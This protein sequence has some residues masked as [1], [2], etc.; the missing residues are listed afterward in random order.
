LRLEERVWRAGASLIG[1]G[2]GGQLSQK[3][4]QEKKHHKK[5]V[6]WSIR[7]FGGCLLVVS[8]SSA[9]PHPTRTQNNETKQKH[10]QAPTR[11]LQLARR[12]FS[13]HGGANL[14]LFIQSRI[15]ERFLSPLLSLSLQLPPLP[16]TA[17]SLFTLVLN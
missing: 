10:S 16:S 11:S 8:H 1:V 14:L 9:S 6:V 12:L 4:K 7:S 15:K 2:A 5:K 13:P 3:Q 17:E